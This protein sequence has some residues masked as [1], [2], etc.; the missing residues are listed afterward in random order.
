MGKG[1]PITN[2]TIPILQS[3]MGG[4][5]F[6]VLAGKLVECSELFRTGP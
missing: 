5:S 2:N 6:Q 4:D 1:Q 3:H